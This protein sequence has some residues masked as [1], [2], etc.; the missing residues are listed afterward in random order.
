MEPK[1][2]ITDKQEIEFEITAGNK[3][4]VDLHYKQYEW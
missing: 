4:T 1:S 3:I 2:V